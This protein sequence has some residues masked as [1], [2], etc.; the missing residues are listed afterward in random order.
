MLRSTTLCEIQPM[1]QRD[2]SNSHPYHGLVLDTR[3]VASLT[4]SKLGCTTIIF[5]QHGAKINGQYY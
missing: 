2:A 4:V 1:S 3:A 5:I